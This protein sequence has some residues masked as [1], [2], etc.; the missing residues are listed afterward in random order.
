MIVGPARPLSALSTYVDGEGDIRA[1][2]LLR[3]AA[4]PLVVLH[5]APFLA[6]ALDGI[7]YSDRFTAPYV[8]GYPQAGPGLYFAILWVGV[9]AAVL[10]SLGLATR[11]AAV[12]TA[13]V[14]GYNLLLSRTHFSH[15]R[16]FLLV[17]LVG[18]AL[19][20]VGGRWSIDAARR[21]RQGRPPASTRGQLW[22]LLLMRFEVVTVYVASATSKLVDPD[23]WGGTVTRLRVV[24]WQEVAAGSGVPG[25]LL[26]VATAPEFHAWFAKAAVLTELAIGLG[27]VFRRTRLGAVWLAIPFHISIELLASVQVFSYAALAALVIWV[28]PEAEDRTVIVRGNTPVARAIATA[29]R[30]LD[31][32]G[33]FALMTL[34]EPGPIMSLVDR[35]GAEAHGAAAA[36]R[37]ASRFPLT[38]WVAAPLNLPAVRAVWNRAAAGVFGPASEPPTADAAV[39]GRPAR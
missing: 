2:E 21:R 7:A 18:L 32:T 5:L 31:W 12:T 16:F 11:V 23:W 33:R 27:L 25:W 10:L 37:I 28:T 38:F 22:P 35:D 34:E 14:V 20:P 26:D 6:L 15:N 1:V 9:A 3:M 36:R 13:A 17:L 39:P 4:G 30:R 29:M 8:A 19:L 24:Q